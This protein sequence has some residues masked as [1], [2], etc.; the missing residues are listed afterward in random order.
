MG[1][2]IVADPH[3]LFTYSCAALITWLLLL[4]SEGWP[5]PMQDFL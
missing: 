1:V 4:G 2:R 5:R 3:Y